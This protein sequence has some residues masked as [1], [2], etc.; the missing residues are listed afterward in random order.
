MTN[1]SQD[2]P[3]QQP[4]PL[5]ILIGINI[6]IK[7]QNAG[8]FKKA[9]RCFIYALEADSNRVDVWYRIGNCWQ[10][11]GY[12]EDA[13]ASYNACNQRSLVQQN[14]WFQAASQFCL[15]QCYVSLQQQDQAILVYRLA[16]QL[17]SQVENNLHTQQSW[18]YL[19]KIGNELLNNQQFE[20]AIQ[21]YHSLLEVVKLVNN[22]QNLS[23]VLQSL[24][25]VYYWQNQDELA[26]E[27]HRQ[28]LDISRR[29]SDG[30]MENT[31]LRWLTSETWRLGQIETAIDY[32]KQRLGVIQR[33]QRPQEQPEILDWIIKGYKQLNQL[34]NTIDYYQQKLGLLR[35]KQDFL[36]EYQT[37]YELGGVYFSLK[38]YPLAIDF[39]QAGLNLEP[40][41]EQPYYHANLNYMLGLIYLALNQASEAIASF[42]KAV[43]VYEQQEQ[44]QEWVIRASEYLEKLYQQTEDFE[45]LIPILEK[46]LS[47]LRESQDRSNEYS[48]L[49]KIAGLYYQL[50]NYSQAGDYYNSALGVAQGLTPRQP[51]LEANAYYMLGLMCQ[52]LQRWEEGLL[53]YREALRFYTELNNQEWVE[54]SRNKVQELERILANRSSVSISQGDPQLDFL[55][56]VLQAV[57]ESRGNPQIVYPLFQQNLDKLDENL[58]DLLTKWATAKF[59]Q[60]SIEE[61]TYMATVIVSFGDL[62]QQF[63]LGSRKKN[64]EISIAAYQAALEI[65]T[66]EAFPEQWAMTQNNL[67]NA[68]SE[69]IK[70]EK[71]DNI[72][73]A[74]ETY[75]AALEIRTREAFPKDWATTQN[76]L[77]G[78]YWSRIKGEKADNIERAIETHQ[79]GLEITTREAFPKQWADTQNNLANAYLSR[80][81]G[82]KADNIE[83]AIAFYQAALEITTRAAFPK[84][85]AATQNNLALAYSNRIKGEK[86]DNIKKAIAAY[87]AALEIRTRAA[88]PYDYLQT[89]YNLGRAYQDIQQWQLAYETFDN[90]I[91]TLEE[92]RAGIVKGGDADKQKLAEEWQYLY[93]RMVEVCIELKNYTA[94]IEYVER[95]K[96][97]NLVELLATRD[98]YPKGDIPQ[99]VKDE[100]DRLRRN[101][102]TEQRR[103][104]IEER[105]RKPFG[106]GTTGERSPNIAALQTPP[107]DRSRLNKL[108]Q[109]LDKLITRDITPIDGDFRLTQKVE[110]IPFSDIQALTGDNTAIL[111]WYILSDRFVVFIVTP[112]PLTPAYQ[113]GELQTSEPPLLRGAGGIKPSEPSED[114][115]LTPPYQRG[116][117]ENSEPPFLRGAGGIKLWQSTPEDY[118]ALIA[119]A[120]DYLTAYRTD[121]QQWQNTLTSRLQRLG[122]ILHFDQLLNIIGEK[123]DR[124]VLIPNRFLHLFPLHALPI[125]QDR[126]GELTSSSGVGAR[127]AS[128]LQESVILM[129]LFSGGVSYAPSCQL[130]QTAK[131]RQR[132]DFSQLFA[133]Q[134]PTEDLAYTDLEVNSIRTYFNSSRGVADFGYDFYLLAI[135]KLL[136]TQYFRLLDFHFHTL[137][138]QRP[139]R[140]LVHENAKKSTFNLEQ[141]TT[142]KTANCHHFSCHG[143]FN[144]ENPILSALLFADCYLEPPP[145]PLDPSR[146]LRLEKGQTLDLSECLTL[147]DV[148][149]LDL[150]CCR[151]VT[152]S[153]C[154]TGL[155]D[156]Q[157]N[158]DEYIGL[159]SG[160][161]VAGSTNVVSS[162]WAVSDISTAILM[163]KFYQLLR[164]GEEVAI[165]L[166]HAQNWLRN[167]TKAELLA[168]IDLGNKMQLRQSLQNMNDN[169]KPFA[170]PYYWA[171]FCAIGK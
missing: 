90:A 148:F 150:R 95:S 54:H 71:A 164:K 83:S 111:E 157:S 69:R 18:D 4:N 60:I 28:M 43:A 105:T 103:L 19:D 154:E 17:F 108:W 10:N 115:P 93:Q 64:L 124:L 79:A 170:S 123:C 42:E 143:Y 63:S 76:N 97:R 131:N 62:I 118:N 158:S 74:I 114:P 106:D 155:I 112:P 149:T 72:E 120:D 132:P 23:S 41:L 13:I 165:A 47:R 163:I 98:L 166:N 75:Q 89:S 142:L 5:L 130:L 161:L 86:A 84:D 33:L 128:P 45:K 134:N 59:K 40:S 138:Q 11:L 121:K 147:G 8:K 119:W 31:A 49:Y 50:K 141:Q 92:I 26:I 57:L 146:H 127:R 9:L 38:Q 12:L 22:Q 73:R 140:I 52:C 1:S 135:A 96:T 137:V 104:E 34:E 53:N 167:A 77:A 126:L 101:I 110:P 48:L 56:D 7:L 68:Y 99:T 151:L 159:P 100:L 87:K 144:F 37:L 169:D 20:S 65:Y 91:E 67:A 6:G 58:A 153:A 35:E 171:A 3:T 27:C 136:N 70:G 81:K 14:I 55:L 51:G 122:E 156:F 46:R 160:F 36:T 88:F 133:I 21:Y 113:S 16:Y 102:E 109:K 82:E 162:L 80:I 117:L 24:G 61:A 30:E 32:F 78:A 107:P 94:A 2:A 139:S 85:W 25:K 145:S 66:R 129:D 44:S 39:F 168:W 116:E 152:L 15:G 125:S 29:L